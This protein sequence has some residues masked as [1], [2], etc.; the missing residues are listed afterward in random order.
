MKKLLITTMAAVSVGL[1]AK[2]EDTGF[3]S[4]T[5][6]ETVPEKSYLATDGETT[7]CKWYGEADNVLSDNY[8]DDP[9][10]G[11]RYWMTEATDAQLVVSNL[12]N[13]AGDYLSNANRPQKWSSDENSKALYI[14]TDKPLMRYVHPSANGTD[15]G[16]ADLNQDIFFDSVVQFTATDVAADP[17]SADKLRVWLYTSPDDVETTPGLFGE[18]TSKTCLVVTAGKYDGDLSTSNLNPWH[19]EVQIDGVELQSDTWHRLTIKAIADIDPTEDYATPGFEIWVDG[20]PVTYGY[21]TDKKTQF[22]SLKEA[23]TSGNETLQCVAFDGKG[24]VDDIV[25]TK[26]APDFAKEDEPDASKV[27]NVAITTPDGVGIVGVLD[28]EGNAIDTVDA[29]GKYVVGV[30]TETITVVVQY[31]GTV[32]NEGAELIE[33][34]TWGI[35]VDVSSAK[36]GD[37][38]Q[39]EITVASGEEPEDPAKPTIGGNSYETEAAL[40]AVVKDGTQVTVPSGW[41]VEGKVLKDNT[42]AIFATFEYYNLAL[43]DGIVT[44]TLDQKAA[45]PFAEATDL[46]EGQEVLDLDAT[47]KDDENN[48]LPAVGIRIKT[49]KGLYYGLGTATQLGT[50][51]VPASWTQS[52]SDGNVIQLV[53]PKLG[54]TG[55][56]KIE[57]RDVNPTSAP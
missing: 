24:A 51:T 46:T 2:A 7:L 20:K 6:F 22:P 8:S 9:E 12:T 54:D 15:A 56:Y 43:A 17:D 47:M 31:A 45:A 52:D 21:G 38:I 29:E 25:F 11:K 4:G 53:A 34:G 26:T 13:F 16:G 42:G 30:D 48:D 28:A 18:T 37:L 44:A 5:S 39:V 23:E 10:L 57:V 50:W 36:E 33:T 19:Y 3:I 35:P 14:D 27:F 41:T 49:F 1:C 40:K 32:T 55:F